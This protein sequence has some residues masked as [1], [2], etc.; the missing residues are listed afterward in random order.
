MLAG[1]EPANRVAVDAVFDSVSVATTFKAELAKAGVIFCRSRRPSANIPTGAPVSRHGRSGH[2]Q[3]LRDAEL[4]RLHRRVVR[5]HPAGRALPDGAV[6]LFPH[7]REEYRPV[8]A[9]ADHRRQGLLRVLSRGL[10]GARSA[11]RTSSTPRWSSS[12]P[13]TTPRSNTRPCRTGIRATREGRGGIYNFVTKRGDCR[14]K[15]SDHH[16]DAGRDRLGD[17]LEISVLHPARRQLA[18]RVL[19]DRG[20]ERHA[21]GRFRH[22]DDPSRQEHH[23]PD[24]LEGHLGRARREHLSRAS[25]RRIARRRA[26]A[27]SPI[28]TRC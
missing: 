16:L 5:L 19:L 14:G 24:H 18:R 3:L 2:R 21:A 15:N 6:D 28:A 22:Q 4:G 12:S 23:E 17:H 26:R 10:H 13:S 11:T 8:R 27:T 1:V 9:H 7:Q 20:F 25:F